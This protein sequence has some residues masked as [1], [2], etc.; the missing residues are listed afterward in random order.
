VVAVAAGAGVVGVAAGPLLALPIGLAGAGVGL[1]GCVI[2]ISNPP[3]RR[4]VRQYNDWAAAHPE[5]LDRPVDQAAVE[6][7]QAWPAPA[8]DEAAPE[9]P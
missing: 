1:T 8:V 3:L 5:A 9:A 6:A 7:A 2:G 4:A